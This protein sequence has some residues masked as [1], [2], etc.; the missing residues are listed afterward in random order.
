MITSFS[1]I[2]DTFNPKWA[3]LVLFSFSLTTKR[4]KFSNEATAAIP[5]AVLS[6]LLTGTPYSAPVLLNGMEKLDVM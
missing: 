4:Y 1:F 3:A 5:W 2:F 6:K